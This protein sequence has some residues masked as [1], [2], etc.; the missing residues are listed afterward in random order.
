MERESSPE[1]TNIITLLRQAH[2]E[3]KN[4][5]REMDAILDLPAALFEL[6][7]RIRIALEAHAAGE[8]FA[9]YGPMREIPGLSTG[10]RRGEAAHEEIDRTLRVLD[11]RP[12]RKEQL[13][14]PEWKETFRQLH[15]TVLAHLAEEEENIFPRLEQLLAE[16]RLDALG[17][18]YKRGLKGELA[19]VSRQLQR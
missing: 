8:A 6:Y 14:S 19:P 18:R 2:W 17:D 7:P 13:D 4:L 9:L 10:L 16:S 3:I 12:S 1:A 5:L 15:R 11:R